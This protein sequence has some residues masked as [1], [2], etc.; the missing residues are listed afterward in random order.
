MSR[1]AERE[2]RA[3]QPEGTKVSALLGI[4]P[5]TLFYIKDLRQL[6]K[7]DL[8]QGSQQATVANVPQGLEVRPIGHVEFGTTRSRAARSARRPRMTAPPPALGTVQG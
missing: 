2:S 3:R 8:E 1:N 6:C 7:V 4:L 5:S